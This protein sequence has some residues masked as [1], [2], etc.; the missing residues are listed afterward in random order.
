M[1]IKFLA[2]LSLC[3]LAFSCKKDDPG[4]GETSVSNLSINDISLLE[5][6]GETVFSF[7][8][9]LDKATDKNVNVRVSTSSDTAGE[10]DYVSKDEE[11]T[12]VAGE[13]SANFDV[14]INGDDIRE[15]DEVF[16]VNLSSVTN[17]TVSDDKGLGTIRNEDTKIDTGVDGYSTP[18][19][20]PGY[21]INWSDEFDGDAV[22]NDIWGYNIGDNGWGN[23][24]L[25]YY[26]NDSKNSFIEN[27]NLIIKA[28][29]EDDGSYTSARLL[30][31]DKKEFQYGRVDVRAKLPE[32]QGVWPA[33]WMLGANIS[34]I[35]WPACGELDIMELVGHEPN[36]V[37]ATA[38][39]GVEGSPSIYNGKSTIKPEGYQDVYHVFSVIWEVSKVTFLVDEEPIHVINTSNTAGY[40]YPFNAP[41]FM[42][43]NVAVGGNWPGYP[44]DTTTFPQTMTVD[45]VRVFKKI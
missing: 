27:G 6:N 13:T 42:I 1:K 37:H 30:T 17:A 2:L 24:E 38:H 8:L 16:F 14:V 29:R 28:I 32:G 41:F 34:D 11:V 10:D 33:I 19:E 5:G 9:S 18:S 36:K 15:Q 20:Y 23:N 4:S 43:M 22:N 45:Y 26:T 31:Q 35:S 39:W 7:V 44:D 12:I 25:Q 21:S 40:N 3:I